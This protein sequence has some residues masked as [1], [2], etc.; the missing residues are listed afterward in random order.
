MLRW[1]IAALMLAPSSIAV[2]QTPTPGEVFDR[3]C[4]AHLNGDTAQAM[5][6]GAALGLE[7]INVRR[8]SLSSNYENALD[9]RELALDGRGYLVVLWSGRWNATEDF[10]ANSLSVCRMH[11]PEGM[12]E[13]DLKSIMESRTR[14][15]NEES[16]APYGPGGWYRNY[17]DGSVSGTDGLFTAFDDRRRQAFVYA[18]RSRDYAR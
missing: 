3:I 1:L 4:P 15:W 13:P 14:G 2:A 5:A 18:T 6:A 16:E 10:P 11:V 9:V 8:D 12:S 7:P 17:E